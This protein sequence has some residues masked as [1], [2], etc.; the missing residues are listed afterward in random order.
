MDVDRVRAGSWVR[1][2]STCAMIS[3]RGDGRRVESVR[4]SPERHRCDR[5]LPDPS[6]STSD[7]KL[8]S[9]LLGEKKNKPVRPSLTEGERVT[10]LA[11]ASWLL[12]AAVPSFVA[13]LFASGALGDGTTDVLE[14]FGQTVQEFVESL[15]TRIGG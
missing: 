2:L 12:V 14:V 5:Q 6:T 9:V 15:Y 3:S 13:I 1:A 8:A 4:A 10:S 11:L 7:G